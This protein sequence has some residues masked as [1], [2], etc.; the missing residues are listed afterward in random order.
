MHTNI[1]TDQ[2]DRQSLAIKRKG[3]QLE[4]VFE[5]DLVPHVEHDAKCVKSNRREGVGA[6]ALPRVKKYIVV[7]WARDLLEE[8]VDLVFLQAVVVA[9]LLRQLAIAGEGGVLGVNFPEPWSYDQMNV[10][11]GSQGVARTRTSTLTCIV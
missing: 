2:I 7:P 4:V 11:W 3:T 6:L 8:F 10:S 1:D 5:H 9:V